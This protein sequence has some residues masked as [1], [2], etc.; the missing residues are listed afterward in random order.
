MSKN[1]TRKVIFS[2]SLVAAMAALG[3]TVY[4]VGTSGQRDNVQEILPLESTSENQTAQEEPMV[5]VGTSQV[6]ADM[7]SMD[8]EDF[9][10]GIE[11]DVAGSGVV[12]GVGTITGTEDG[13][14]EAADT[15]IASADNLVDMAAAA[16]TTASVYTAPEINFSEDTLM[17]WP[18]HGTILIDYSM[19]QTTYFPTLD[20]YKLNPAIVIQSGEGA[21][22]VSAVNGTVYSIEDTAETGTTVT[23]ELGNGYQAI[24]GQLTDLNISEGDTVTKGTTIGYVAAPTKYYN[25]EGSNLYFAMKKDGKPIDPIAYLP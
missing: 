8:G 1:R 19:D 7:S 11:T 5:D 4:Q 12:A 18:L 25:T 3:I 10:A 13:I 6:E 24:Y 15:N 16:D 9:L 23:M 21:P 22:V 14:D 20:Q 17:E 2:G